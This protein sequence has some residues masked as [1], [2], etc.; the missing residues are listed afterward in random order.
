MKTLLALLLLMPSLSWGFNENTK[1][2]DPNYIFKPNTTH[3]WEEENGMLSDSYEI[4]SNT[5]SVPWAHQWVTDITRD[6]GHA[7]RLE[8]RDGDCND[9][10]CGRKD[11]YHRTEF[12]WKNGWLGESWYRFSAYVPKETYVEYPWMLMLMQLKAFSNA[13]KFQGS[14]EC[15]VQP[16]FIQIDQGQLKFTQSVGD[17][18]DVSFQEDYGMRWFEKGI[19]DRWLDF[20]I[21]SNT[22]DQEDGFIYVWVNGE[23]VW[24]HQ[25]KNI[26]K[27]NLKYPPIFMHNVYEGKAPKGMDRKSII[28]FDAF[29]AAK[30]CE[31]MK[32]DSLGYSCQW[33]KNKLPGATEDLLK[34]LDFAIQ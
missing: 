23:L 5:A 3:K 4:N 6:G 31:E 16:L 1:Y 26:W 12:H 30:N 7:I 28:Y 32:L 17:T 33:L 15:P 20:V 18:C 24:E 9:R 34:E 2:T 13:E 21:Y 25:G 22:T 11:N 14:K 8:L 19:K 27:K 29:Y 10:D